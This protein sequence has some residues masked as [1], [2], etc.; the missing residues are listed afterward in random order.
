MRVVI[1]SGISG[2]GKSTIA[3]ALAT[4]PE[5]GKVW[6]CSADDHF[7]DEDGVYKFDFTKLGDAHAACM[8]KFADLMHEE[9]MG[10]GGVVDT[11]IVD[12][13]NTSAVEIAPYVALA[14]AYG[15]KCEIVT[16]LIDPVVAAQRNLHG[17]PEAGCKRMDAALRGRQLPPFWDVKLTVVEH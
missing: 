3:M 4:N 9:K 14:A 7:V 15:V 16:I 17:V 5:N 12:N 1:L 6:R 2:S 8:F 11:L 10:T 13:T